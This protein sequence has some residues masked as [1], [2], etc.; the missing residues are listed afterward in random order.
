[1]FYWQ[2]IATNLQSLRKSL[3]GVEILDGAEEKV[4]WRHVSHYIIL[5]TSFIF[6]DICTFSYDRI[7]TR[8]LYTNEIFVWK[9]IHTH[10][11]YVP[12]I[13]W[14]IGKIFAWIDH[15][16]MRYEID[17]S[18]SKIHERELSSTKLVLFKSDR[19]VPVIN[20]SFRYLCTLFDQ[21]ILLFFLLFFGQDLFSRYFYVA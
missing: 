9:S 6:L 17:S 13:W 21:Y 20:Y 5:M 3:P 14:F 16:C 7:W 15:R 11:I 10:I 18:K 2:R 19:N 4:I 8:C 12:L 1:M